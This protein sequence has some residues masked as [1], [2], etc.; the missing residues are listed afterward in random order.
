MAH[1]QIGAN[2]DNPLAAEFHKLID[3]FINK[4]PRSF[5]GEV[6]EEWD[7][8]SPSDRLVF[9][10]PI[11]LN[12]EQR[13]I[14][15]ALNKDGC[16]YI[17]VE[18]PPGTGKSHTITAVVFEAILR[19][20]SVLVLSDKKEA[21]DV[22]EDKITETMDRVRY[23]K[24]FQNPI[25]RLGR[26]GSTYSQ[27]LSA[28]SIDN[29]KTHHRAVKKE[30]ENV[31]Q[32]IAR[33]GNSLREDL[34][35]EI[36]AYGEVDAREIR[37]VE[38]LEAAI[39]KDRC[40]IEIQEWSATEEGSTEL[41]E[42]RTLCQMLRTALVDAPK[43]EAGLAAALRLLGWHPERPVEASISRESAA[44]S[45]DASQSSCQSRIDVCK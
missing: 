5:N 34:E 39:D 36:L 38:E 1:S 31:E 12:S 3:D 37:E 10:S 35:A 30:Y 19:D 13:Q 11:P 4:E 27:I 45:F 18:G 23:D 29:I 32:E 24:K 15:T 28:A 14:L 2:T 41:E 26:T 9:N 43:Q 20:Q 21:L 6:E 40:P 16:R 42:F 33:R 7:S 17:T 8:A 44:I 25:L 22:V